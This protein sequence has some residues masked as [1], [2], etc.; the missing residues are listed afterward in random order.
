[1]KCP[2]SKTP[3]VE[4]V[5]VAF[6]CDVH[7]AQL[8]LE[9]AAFNDLGNLGVWFRVAQVSGAWADPVS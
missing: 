1:M 4:T 5:L 3:V 8:D 6:W 9:R 2:W 7:V